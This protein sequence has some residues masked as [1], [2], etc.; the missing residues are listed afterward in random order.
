M[1]KSSSNPGPAPT[2]SATVTFE[3]WDG[4]MRRTNTDSKGVTYAAKYDE[5]D[6]PVKN[7]PNATTISLKRLNDYSY[8]ATTKLNGKVM[9]VSR[10]VVSS[11]GKT[12]TVIVIG[13]DAKGR[14]FA[15]V[16]VFDR[17]SQRLEGEVGEPPA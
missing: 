2:T 17:Q 5:K 13:K 15:N 12:R 6:Y 7:N 9:Q 1:A 3:A 8:E 11:D 4:G 14:A 16:E 10:A